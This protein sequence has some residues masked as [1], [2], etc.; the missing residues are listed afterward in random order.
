MEGAVGGGGL[1]AGEGP[2]GDGGKSSGG[3]SGW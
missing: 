3:D 2:V 1:K